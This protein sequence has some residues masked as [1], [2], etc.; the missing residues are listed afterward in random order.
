M[1]KINDILKP[2]IGIVLIISFVMAFSSCEKKNETADGKDTTIRY[3]ITK[4]TVIHNETN[5]Q[6]SWQ[7]RIKQESSNLGI[8]LD[9][10]KDKA[11]RTGSKAQKEISEAVDK[12]NNERQQ[13]QSDSSS[14]NWKDKW[15]EYKERAKNNIDSLKKKI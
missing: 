9:S 12:L 1:E 11:K 13:I 7:E 10:L 5:E 6:A 14:S 3:K 15:A 2:V 4:D 8:E